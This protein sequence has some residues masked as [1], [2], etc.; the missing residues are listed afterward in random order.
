MIEL[1]NRNKYLVVVF[2]IIIYFIII[3]IIIIS[4]VI[5]FILRLTLIDIRRS[6]SLIA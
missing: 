6:Q 5:N 4:S 3:I 1:K 2:V